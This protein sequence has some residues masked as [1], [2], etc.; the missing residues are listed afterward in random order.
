MTSEVR[1]IAVFTGTRA[2]YGL[3]S[4]LMARLRDDPTIDFR[5]I[6][7]SMHFAPE[8]GETWRAIVDD[9]FTIDARVEMLLASDSSLGTV[10]SL[11]LGTIGI[12]D[13]LDRLAPDL[14]VILGDRF[15]ALA[16]A[17]A[18]L[19][20]RIPIAHIHGGEISEGAFDDAI[21]HAISKMAT[22]H[23]P[24]AELF[25]RRLI[26]MGAPPDRV[27]TTGAP[28]LDGLMDGPRPPLSA[29]GDLGLVLDRPFALAT[30]HPA[31]AA[32]EDAVAGLGQLLAALDARPDLPVI[33]TYPNADAGGR[34]IIAALRPWAEARS[35]R[36]VAVPS[37]GHARYR[38]ALAHAAVV[39]G[40]SS[41]GL[42]EAP[43]FGLPTVN[44]GARQRGRLSA[45]SVLHCPA[46]TGAILATLDT[47]LSPEHRALAAR[48]D[49][50]YGKGRAAE[51]IHAI[52][53]DRP[54]PRDLPFYD[55]EPA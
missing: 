17:Q 33:F 50:H 35:D 54:I 30:W 20:L 41:S 25:R 12:A 45:A 2:E 13:A 3:L 44:I 9:G 40:N 34:A 38:A 29:L 21:R 10:K 39:L 4:R 49:S 53:R 52:L 7:G 11:G 19:I 24:A 15:E 48:A 42:I 1:R 18:A 27:F 23:F 46:E 37:L 5:L 36:A 32:E 8:F 16:A 26:R 47:A 6:V 43:A 31:T 22:W 51:A 28:G 55:G 14:L